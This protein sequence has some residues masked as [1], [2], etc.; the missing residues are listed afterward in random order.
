MSSLTNRIRMWFSAIARDQQLR[1]LD[2]P[3]LMRIVG[4][5]G[6]TVGDFY[7]L[8]RRGSDAAALL[9][10]RLR[11]CGIDPETISRK[12]PA[13]MR[14][15][16]RVCAFCH[17]RGTCAR[18]LARGQAPERWRTYCPNGPT[19]EDLAFNLPE[20]PYAN[21]NERKAI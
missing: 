14:D 16:Q 8:N 2:K 5:A 12:S 15:M 9:P 4:E 17:R 18:D 13:T 21:C 19:I 20:P 6:I 10:R 7:A 1:Q 11:A 3:E